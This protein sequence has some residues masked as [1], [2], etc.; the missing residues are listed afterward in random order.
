MRDLLVIVPVRGRPASLARFTE[1]F[2]AT[3]RTADLL[4]V[5]DVDDRSYDGAETDALVRVL[6]R[7]PTGPKVNAAAADHLDYRA[8]MFMG[9]DNVCVT[10]GWDDIMLTALGGMGGTGILWPDDLSEHA[11]LPCSA[12]ISCDIVSALGWMCLPGAAHFFVD[13]VWADLGR[14]A[15]CLMRCGGAV[16]EHRHPN[17]GKAPRDQLYQDA[18]R[19]YWRHDKAAYA[20]WKTGQMQADIET[21]RALR[22]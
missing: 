12:M 6:P 7:R 8:L 14:G 15:G 3:A 9:D 1:A 4:V 5:F 17:Y 21:V 13:N 22:A 19:L 2:R 11:D 16:I 20:A 10:P 18:M